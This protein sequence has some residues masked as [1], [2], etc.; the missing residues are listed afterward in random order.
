[1]VDFIEY[2]DEIFPNLKHYRGVS[3]NGQYYLSDSHA[4]YYYV[5]KNR[6]GND[7]TFTS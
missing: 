4:L 1:M 2:T 6:D 7:A 3:S 5:R